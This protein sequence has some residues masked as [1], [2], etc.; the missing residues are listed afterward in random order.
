MALNLVRVCLTAGVLATFS[1]AEAVAAE[2]WVEPTGDALVRAVAAAEPGD[3]LCLAPGDHPGGIVIDKAITVIGQPGA[4]IVGPGQGRVVTLDAP[5]IVLSGLTI[6]GSGLKL[7]T[8]DSGVFVTKRATDARIEGNRFEDNLI[9]VYLKGATDA[10]VKDN[11]IRGRQDLRMNERGN[12]VQ[13]WNAPGAVV[14]GNDIRYGR[15]GIFVTTSKRN[16]FRGN[17]FRDLRFGIHYMYTNR[18]E[19]SG[20]R[21]YG[22]H[23]GYAH[24]V[25]P[26]PD[27]ARDNRSQTATA[28]TACC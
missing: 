8:E 2:R 12:G 13:V 19:V 20:N 24:H 3:I 25:L 14:E 11:V 27:H 5:G 10:V 28:T 22:N 23:A 21:S 15:D 17:A 6:T 7:E 9:G 16:I 1:V 4:R 18:S 26:R